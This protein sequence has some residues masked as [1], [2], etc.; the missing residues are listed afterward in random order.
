ME[1][2]G[3]TTA[4]RALGAVL[5][6][7]RSRRMG[8]D[9]AALQ[10]DGRPMISL[11]VDALRPHASDVVL[12]SGRTP[13]YLE[14]GLECVL[15]DGEDQGPLGG[16]VAAMRRLV[17]A[18]D[19]A[20][21]SARFLYVLACDMPRADARVF[22]AL[23]TRM[24]ASGADACLLRDDEGVEPLFAIYRGTA[25]EAMQ[26]SLDGGGRRL[27][28]F[29]SALHVETVDVGELPLGVGADPGRNVNTMSDFDAET[30]GA[31]N[32]QPETRS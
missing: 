2:D 18:G 12:A 27:I 21:R 9:K 6:G 24:D 32:A 20:P 26:R 15:D 3:Q 19:D 17:E 7:G 30:N 13:R 10:I 16:L 4:I 31:R 25:F 29:H 14:L 5:C 11:A 28:S 8:V 1:D 22:D 23:R